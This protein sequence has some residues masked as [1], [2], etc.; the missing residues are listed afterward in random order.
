[1]YLAN[2]SN[3]IQQNWEFA[4]SQASELFNASPNIFSTNFCRWSMHDNIRVSGNVILKPVQE[5]F[6]LE[7][8]SRK[9]FVDVVHAM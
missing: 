2:M 5:Q 9:L 8:M 7:S 1:M 4:S 3:Q 6:C